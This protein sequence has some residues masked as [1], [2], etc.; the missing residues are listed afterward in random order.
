MNLLNLLSS[1]GDS[2]MKN[3]TVVTAAALTACLGAG[4]HADAATITYVDAVEGASGNTFATASGD[5]T[6]TSWVGGNTS[7]IL[8]DQWSKRPFGN[9][10]TIFQG[11]YNDDGA[12]FPELTTQITGL[13]DGLYD[14][15]VFFWSSTDVTS[16]VPS[17][18]WNIAGGLT[19]GDL[20]T[21]S[22]NGAGD[23]SSTVAAS[24]LDFDDTVVTQEGSLNNDG[25]SG[26][27]ILYG[28]NLGE[29]TVSGG[30]TI[31]VFIDNLTGEGA[32]GTDRTWYDGVGYQVVPEPGSGAMAL[33]GLGAMAM[34]RRRG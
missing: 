4:L 2:A 18:T 5:L 31:D 10:G 7:G 32:G 13:S 25:V 21:Y 8:N 34:R 30:S 15:W 26:L 27:R 33:I 20:T 28:V 16:G 22:F 23:T 12:V 14:V 9:G 1:T 17:Q 3:Q 29:A 11:R 6:D 24:T 19:S